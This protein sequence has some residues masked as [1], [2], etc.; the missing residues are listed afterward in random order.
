MPFLHYFPTYYHLHVHFEHIYLAA[1]YE[2]GMGKNILL[3]DVIQNIQM[4]SDY[5]QE[6]DI[7]VSLH[8]NT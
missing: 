1:S 3:N 2:S 6:I 4:K 5:Y 7:I 8:E